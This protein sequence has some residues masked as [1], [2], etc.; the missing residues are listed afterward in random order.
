MKMKTLLTLNIALLLAFN[1]FSQ[2]DTLSF[3]KNDYLF[4]IN[5]HSILDYWQISDDSVDYYTNALLNANAKGEAFSED[6]ILN[7]GYHEFSFDDLLLII[8]SNHSLVKIKR[9]SDNEWVKYKV[10]IMKKKNPS[11]GIGGSSE[12]SLMIIDKKK[13]IEIIH[14]VIGHSLAC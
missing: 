11:L 8:E 13:R 2:K 5:L 7:F 4:Q 12:T 9:I 6:T 1:S 14:E 10:K 3:I